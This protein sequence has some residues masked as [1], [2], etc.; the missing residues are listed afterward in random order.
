MRKNN[1]KPLSRH[2]ITLSK[3]AGCGKTRR[4]PSGWKSGR[5]ST[6][7]TTPPTRSSTTSTTRISSSTSSTTT[8][9]PKTVSGICSTTCCAIETGKQK[10]R[11]PDPVSD[12]IFIFCAHVT[13]HHSSSWFSFVFFFCFVHSLLPVSANAINWICYC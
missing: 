6:T 1:G 9:P 12:Y 11:P 13:F 3:H 2:L 8:S 4:S 10:S 7:P 5:V